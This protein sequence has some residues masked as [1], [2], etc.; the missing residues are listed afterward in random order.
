[1][2]IF[3]FLTLFL[4]VYTKIV[5]KPGTGHNKLFAS[6]GTNFRFVGEIKNGLNRVSVVTSI[7]IPRFRDIQ[8]NPIHYRDC[9]LEFLSDSELPS[10]DFSKILNNWC[11]EVIPYIDHLKK[12]E[13]YYMERLHD[14]LEEDLY[15]ALPK[16]KL[17]VHTKVRHRSRQ[18]LGAILLSVMPD[19]ITMT[20]ESIFS[21]IKNK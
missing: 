19:L 18:G 20:V 3:I 13:K 6:Y 21:F 10:D 16:L 1:M 11:A 12:K 4:Y 17:H 9:T 7:P 14:L 15:A 5:L 2:K 8:V